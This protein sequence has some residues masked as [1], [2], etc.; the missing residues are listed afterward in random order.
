MQQTQET[1]D[2]LQAER[3]DIINQIDSLRHALSIYER[4]KNYE[5]EHGT[6][7][8]SEHISRQIRFA[9]KFHDGGLDGLFIGA[10]NVVISGSWNSQFEKYFCNTLHPLSLDR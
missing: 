6:E 2:K 3:P 8:G 4:T 10:L 1:K 7:S 5:I 9:L